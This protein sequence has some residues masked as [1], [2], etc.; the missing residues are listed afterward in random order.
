MKKAV[1]AI[2]TI[3]AVILLA[4]AGG[5][6]FMLHYALAPLHRSD[7]EALQRLAHREPAFVKQWSDSLQLA[8]ALRDTT[9]AMDNRGAMHAWLLEAP[10]ASPH[11]AVLVHGY[12]DCALSMLHI[13]WLYHHELGMNVVMPD[14]YG[15]GHSEGDHIDMGW[16]DRLDVLRWTRVAIARFGAREV[17]LHGISMGAFT[18][19]CAAGEELPP[20][21]AC[22]VEDCGYTSVNDEF[23]HQLRAQ[24]RLSKFPLLLATSVLCK[25]RYGWSFDEAD[26][27]PPLR[28]ATVPVLFIHGGNDDFV[29]T[30]MV[31]RLHRACAAPKELWVAPGA[32]HARS[33]TTHPDEY[34]RR[35]AAFVNRYAP[36]HP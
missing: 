28:R 22:V 30:P 31:R 17:V 25:W 27:L 9:I 7:G 34:T 35:V 29:P 13:A 19:M 32:A 23:E 24:F 5:S 26:A 6:V 12:K 21:V 2:L 18:V 36:P 14:L 10:Q 8:G 3:V 11:T 33:F 1:K 20:Q 16:H 4:V 15:H